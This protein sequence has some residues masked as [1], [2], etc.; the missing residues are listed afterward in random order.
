MS[1]E[2]WA[3]RE[4]FDDPFQQKEAAQAGMWVFLVT[5]VL[6]FGALFTAYTIYRHLYPTGFA[7]GSRHTALLLG[8]LNT[9]VLLTS[10]LTMALS[11]HSAQ[12]GHRGL[13]LFFLAATIALGLGFLGIKGLEWS[14]EIGEHLLPGPRFRFDETFA[15]EARQ[16][17]LFFVLYFIMTGLHAL[18]MIVALGLVAYIAITAW[19]D[20]YG[21]EYFT[22][23]EVSGLYWHFVD[24]V[25]IFLYPLLY[26]IGG[27]R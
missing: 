17:Q 11:V 6:M 24:I 4:Q 20:R 12:V 19:L 18:H 21:P 1:E 10:S 16:V 5:E 25:W 2:T 13:L 8:T 7:E 22:P 26:L 14:K 3:L 15:G 23:V 27:R 9:G